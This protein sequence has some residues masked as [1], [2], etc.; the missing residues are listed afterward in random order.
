MKLIRLSTLGWLLF[1]TLVPMART[2]YV[3]LQSDGQTGFGSL[4]PLQAG[5]GAGIS[6]FFLDSKA[7]GGPGLRANATV[8]GMSA[9]NVGNIQVG[10]DFL[11]PYW[12]FRD[13][14]LAIPAARAGSFPLLGDVGNVDDHFALVPRI[15]YKYDVSDPDFSVKAAGTFLNLSGRLERK[16]SDSK[17][18]E[19]TLTANSTLTI[20]AANIPEFSSRVY[21]G[22]L[23][24]AG[25]LFNCRFFD[26]LAM[27]IGV[28]SRYSSIDQNYTGALT[29]SVSGG[30]N[31]TTRHST[32][33][34]RGI[35]LT[36]SLDLSLPVQ[37]NWIVFSNMRTSILVG[38]N[39]KNS[40][41]AIDVVGMPGSTN[42][43]TQTRTEFVPVL[44]L[45][46]GTEWGVEIGERLRKNAPPPLFTVRAA[47]VSQFWG[48]VGPLSAGS[49]QEYRNSN[50]VLVGA[51]VMVGFHR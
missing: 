43:I 7:A 22:D 9:S 28:G 5:A 34:F 27:D 16:I 10:F 4:V 38:D 45:E 20:I 11:R 23:F 3:P 50:L 44:D 30:T 26:D 19:G 42:I 32:Q 15:V 35:G 40:T 46:L 36:T 6:P 24:P 13:F 1:L 18:G 51:H 41:L 12:S 49:A 14:T 21:Y 17:A 48:G 2:Q 8:A 29:N 37:P 39:I 25:S 47:A 33:V 31:S